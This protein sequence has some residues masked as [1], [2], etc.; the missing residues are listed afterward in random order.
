MAV[1]ALKSTERTCEW[2]KIARFSGLAFL[3]IFLVV[4]GSTACKKAAETGS[5]EVAGEEGTVS[6]EGLLTYE[7]TAKIVQG[8]YL[9]MPSARGFD[10]VIQGDLESGDTATLEGKEIKVAGKYDPE[11]PAVLIAKTIDIKNDQGDWVNAFEMPEDQEII[12]EDFISFDARSE[13]PVM[14]NVTYDKKKDWEGKGKVK[15]YGKLDKS[16]DPHKIILYDE[17]SKF[18]G[19]IIIDQYTD[20]AEYYM[21]KLRLFD[22]F[23]FYIDVKDTIEWRE[24]RRTKEL[25][26]ADVVFIGL[27]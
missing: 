8:Q 25:F 6:K 7:G 15:I 2:R 17:K 5:E 12:L 23:W 3:V 18:A 1:K 20:F 9:F 14:E 13:F 27:F 4:M 22:K 16:E 10:I 26:H 24:R 11:L 21:R 19:K